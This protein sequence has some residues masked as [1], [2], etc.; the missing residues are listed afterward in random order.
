MIYL[1]AC[2][3][4]RGDVRY[5]E[6]MDG[7]QLKCFQCGFTLNTKSE[8]QKAQPEDHHIHNCEEVGCPRSGGPRKRKK[9]SK[10]TPA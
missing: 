2:P 1:K 5:E 4:C 7:P 8:V 3:R 6:G 10:E 9:Q